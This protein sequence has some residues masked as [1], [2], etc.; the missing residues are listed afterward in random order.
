MIPGTSLSGWD[1]RLCH[2]LAVQSSFCIWGNGDHDAPQNCSADVGIKW[3]YI[4][5]VLIKLAG[6]FVC[7]VFT[8]EQKYDKNDLQVTRMENLCTPIS[9]SYRDLEVTQVAKHLGARTWI[10][11][12][13]SWVLDWSS[14]FTSLFLSVF[15]HCHCPLSRQNKAQYELQC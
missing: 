4:S 5:K 12:W 1:F 15:L 8:C 3:A 2:L 9:P 14:N 11:H 10:R 6:I 13:L 7:I